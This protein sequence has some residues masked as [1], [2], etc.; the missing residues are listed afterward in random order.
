MTW[1]RVGASNVVETTETGT[2]KGHGKH[3]EVP[4]ELVEE[5]EKEAKKA[6]EG[7]D[8]EDDKMEES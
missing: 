1:V 2:I 3:E 5:A 4:K 8:E 6:L 7:E